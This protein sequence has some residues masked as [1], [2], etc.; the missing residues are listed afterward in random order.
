MSY[1]KKGYVLLL[2]LFLLIGCTSKPANEVA[3]KSENQELT[4]EP[5]K[6][7]MPQQDNSEIKLDSI[8][9]ILIK[10]DGC[11]VGGQYS[12]D[13]GKPVEGNV[14]DE[15]IQWRTFLETPKKE[16]TEFLLTR[17]D[18]ADT[19]SVHTCPFF[20][21][22]EGELAVYSLQKVHRKCWFDFKE[23]LEFKDKET[24]SSEDNRQRWLQNILRD[25]PKREKLKSL[26]LSEL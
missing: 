17:M 4:Q 16:L 15:N 6:S 25:K 21:A 18:K 22:T 1:R 26:W 12:V 13:N 7:D 19:T 9:N 23:F 20:N 24:T 10:T 2:S 8:W 3:L 5:S 11:L 14:M